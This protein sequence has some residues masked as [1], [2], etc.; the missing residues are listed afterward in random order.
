MCTLVGIPIG[1]ETRCVSCVCCV[2]CSVYGN[3]RDYVLSGVGS[4]VFSVVSLIHAP[5]GEASPNSK[6]YL[7]VPDNQ[8]GLEGK[9]GG[10]GGGV[11]EGRRGWGRRGSRKEDD[12]R[13]SCC[14][15][16]LQKSYSRIDIVVGWARELL[17]IFDK[18]VTLSGRGRK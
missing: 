8:G 14:V 12:V 4:L 15:Y 9:V 7:T 2:L 6:T 3:G 16:Q 17:N 10:G 11:E 13:E 1:G 5:P 18:R